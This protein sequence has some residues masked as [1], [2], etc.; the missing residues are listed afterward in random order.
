MLRNL[1]KRKKRYAYLVN[2][3]RRK[4]S[5]VVQGRHSGSHAIAWAAISISVLQ[6]S[7]DLR[8][9]T[10]YLQFTLLLFNNSL[11]RTGKT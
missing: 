1:G 9:K 8:F 6:I 4:F 5:D 3:K 11:L 2:R 7:Y 10:W